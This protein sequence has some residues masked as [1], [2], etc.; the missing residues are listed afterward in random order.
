LSKRRPTECKELGHL[1]QKKKI[2]S[3]SVIITSAKSD[4]NIDWFGFSGYT[5]FYI[6]GDQCSVNL[7]VAMERSGRMSVVRL[8]AWMFS[9]ANKRIKGLEYD[10]VSSM[11]MNM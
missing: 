7:F 5:R 4:K 1:V 6:G 9:N 10:G 3:A 2:K 11:M 8:A